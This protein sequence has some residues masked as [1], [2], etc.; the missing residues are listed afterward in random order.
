MI[1]RKKVRTVS[2]W[3]HGRLNVADAL[4]GDAVLIVAVHKLILELSD[5]VNQ[6][7]EFVGDVR[8]VVV[9]GFSPNRELLL[10][11]QHKGH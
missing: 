11:P 9:T 4:D 2:A 6:N 1:G 3:L 10:L 7:S 8:H 5:L